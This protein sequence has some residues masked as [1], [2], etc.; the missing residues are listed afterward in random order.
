MRGPLEVSTLI[1]TKTMLPILYC[2]LFFCSDLDGGYGGSYGSGHMQKNPSY[3]QAPSHGSSYSYQ[4]PAFGHGTSSGQSSYGGESSRSNYGYSG[5]YYI[6][7][8][9]PIASTL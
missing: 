3:N 2:A 7:P 5:E 1:C 4:N 9:L 6:L 8:Y